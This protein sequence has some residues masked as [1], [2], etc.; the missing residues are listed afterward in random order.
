[1]PEGFGD[2]KKIGIAGFNIPISIQN[3]TSS[4]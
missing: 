2:I 4:P 1:M 3:V